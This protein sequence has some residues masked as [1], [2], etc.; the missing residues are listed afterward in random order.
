[1]ILKE[2]YFQTHHQ[3]SLTETETHY[4]KKKKDFEPPKLTSREQATKMTVENTD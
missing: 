3:L 1:M 2:L 4:K